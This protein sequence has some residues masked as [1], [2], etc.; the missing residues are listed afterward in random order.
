VNERATDQGNFPEE[1]MEPGVLVVNKHNNHFLGSSGQ[2]AN[3][4]SQNEVHR[5]ETFKAGWKSLV[6]AQENQYPDK[7][8]LF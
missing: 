5:S 3:S 6:S 8:L 2:D 4:W 1:S 7:T